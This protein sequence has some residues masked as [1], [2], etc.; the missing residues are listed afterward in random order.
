LFDP[1]IIQV[2]TK[3]LEPIEYE[4]T[5]IHWIYDFSSGF[6]SVDMEYDFLDLEKN[7]EEK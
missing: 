7:T 6:K 3:K 1:N 5:E 4:E 2:P